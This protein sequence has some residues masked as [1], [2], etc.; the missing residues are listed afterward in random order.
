MKLFSSTQISWNEPWFFIIRIRRATG[1]ANRAFFGLAVAIVLFMAMYLLQPGRGLV[2]S[3]GVSVLAGCVLVVLLDVSNLQREVTIKEDGI[4]VNS[5]V[6]WGWGWWANFEL[7][8]INGINLIRPSE[9]EHSYSG[10]VIASP[11]DD[12]LVAIPNTVSLET[13]ANIL[14]R[15]GVP[16]S[17]EGWE[18]S[19]SDARIDIRNELEIDPAAARGELAMQPIEAGDGPLLT[20]A[21]IA[22]QVVIALGPLLLAVIGAI[23]VG[24]LLYRGWAALGILEKCLY[25]GGALVGIIVAFMYLILVGQFIAASYGVGVARKR[26]QTRPNAMFAG[27]E[28]D[29]VCVEIFDRKSW[30]AVVSKS[31]D[32]GFLQ[33]DRGQSLLR[34]EGNKFRWT[35]PIAALTACRIEESI[36]GS[37]ADTSAERRYYVVIAAA[38]NSEPWAAGMVYTRTEMGN[39]NAESRYNRA[40]LLFAQL[41]DAV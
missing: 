11:A 2:E 24:V 41:A 12:F 21:N 10:M 27:T 15:L 5:S 9:W 3:V 18:P 13:L 34:F 36:V 30:T 40:Q 38:S 31:T 32:Y 4:L 26:L 20:P 37:E 23:A 1:W 29:L 25:G 35:L 33:I 19:D 22:V 39:D 7:N 6:S 8:N 16:V 14:H 28:D 17:L